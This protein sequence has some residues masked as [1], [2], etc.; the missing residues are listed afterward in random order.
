MG[1]DAKPSG[2]LG[3][4][5]GVR[6]AIAVA[7]LSAAAFF[8]GRFAHRAWA[9]SAA[10][11][12]LA[13]NRTPPSATTPSQLSADPRPATPVS[14][15][16]RLPTISAPAGALA[17]FLAEP[18]AHRRNLA[19]WESLR[20]ANEANVQAL[21]AEAATLAPGP[22]RDTAR[23][24]LYRRWG[25]LNPQAALA[26]VQSDNRE[27]R[28]LAEESIVH[29]WA[30]SAPAEAFDWAVRVLEA[31]AEPQMAAQLNQAR[32]DI[33]SRQK[34]VEANATEWAKREPLAAA[35]WGIQQPKDPSF[36]SVRIQ[37]ILRLGADRPDLVDA[38]LNG[39]SSPPARAMALRA[40]SM[41]LAR[42]DPAQACERVF[43]FSGTDE[44]T[45]A[46]TGIVHSWLR[47]DATT[48]AEFVE[49]DPRLT[50]EQRS[51]L[52]KILATP[53]KH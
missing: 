11:T 17:A 37:L 19:F 48:A 14:S 35:E 27:S 51:Q 6:V 10:P 32:E 9:P 3:G 30:K 33:T 41:S 42:V 31:E 24:L 21:L 46:L 22:T 53:P 29:G 49:K 26:S 4:E 34:G 18:A 20:S 1:T 50:P 8:A 52:R 47:K 12:S 43:R 25:E 40:H 5:N 36:D 7:A 2:V 39:L 45:P 44:I 15:A 16:N 23:Q 28:A 13:D 38:L